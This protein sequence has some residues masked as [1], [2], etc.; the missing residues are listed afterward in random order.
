MVRI[1]KLHYSYKCCFAK[2]IK[3]IRNA[4]ITKSVIKLNRGIV[5]ISF[6]GVTNDKKNIRTENYTFRKTYI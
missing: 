3:L 1:I 2:C 6:I 5:I 4:V